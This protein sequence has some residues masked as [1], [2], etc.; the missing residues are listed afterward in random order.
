MK[1][2]LQSTSLFFVKLLFDGQRNNI[3]LT[4]TKHFL[5]TFCIQLHFGCN[6]MQS[7][8]TLLC[9]LNIFGEI[10]ANFKKKM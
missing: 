4:E 10:S 9:Y 3:G 1:D 6:E 8:V 7:S 5:G 2:N